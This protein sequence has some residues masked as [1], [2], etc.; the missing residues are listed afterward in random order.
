MFYK[1]V[2]FQESNQESHKQ[3]KK[4]IHVYNYNW[5]FREQTETAKLIIRFIFHICT[6]FLHHQ[7]PQPASD[8]EPVVS[9]SLRSGSG[10]NPLLYPVTGS[11][12]YLVTFIWAV[13]RECPV[14]CSGVIYTHTH[15]HHHAHQHHHHPIARYFRYSYTV[16]LLL[17]LCRVFLV[18][19]TR[20]DIG[21]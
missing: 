4:K 5:I 2:W 1:Q 11:T 3:R 16:K 17:W 15:H 12:S 8:S 13:M 14:S 19:L 9:G 20:E 7:Q 18:L 6:F 21:C 10:D